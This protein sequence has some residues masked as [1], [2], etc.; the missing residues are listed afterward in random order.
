VRAVRQQ[1]LLHRHYA[2]AGSLATRTSTVRGAMKP[3]M[4]IEQGAV[5]AGAAEHVLR[6]QCCAAVAAPGNADTGHDAND[7][8]GTAPA[9]PG[10]RRALQLK[11]LVVAQQSWV[12][13]LEQVILTIDADAL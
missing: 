13:V 11:E 3:A 7:V 4:A 1:R 6:R 9:V 8:T 10:V 2:A 5:F 12:V